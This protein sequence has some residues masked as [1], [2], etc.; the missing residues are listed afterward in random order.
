MFLGKTVIEGLQKG[1]VISEEMIENTLLGK[2]F[3]HAGYGSFKLR[4][5]VTTRVDDGSP[6]FLPVLTAVKW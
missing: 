1:V 3:R 6:F 2:A 4:P 5:V